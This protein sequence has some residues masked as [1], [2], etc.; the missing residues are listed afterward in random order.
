MVTERDLVMPLPAVPGLEGELQYRWGPI[1]RTANT[2][3][4]QSQLAEGYLAK[5]VG[6]ARVGKRA[7]R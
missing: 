6:V 3:E 1:W 7:S 5:F 4:F 2:S